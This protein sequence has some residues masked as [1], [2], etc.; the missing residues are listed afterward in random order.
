MMLGEIRV[1]SSSDTTKIY[2]I[3]VEGCPDRVYCDCT[4]C[5]VHGYCKH[6]RF[7]K[8]AIKKLLEGNGGEKNE[9]C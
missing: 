7:Y 4:G 3:R 6:I 5:C 9:S 1:A 2:T 8:K